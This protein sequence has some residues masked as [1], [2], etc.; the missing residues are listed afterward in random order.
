MRL[1]R[2]HR[3]RPLTLVWLTADEA[4]LVRGDGPAEEGREGPAV[5][6][7]RSG[8]PELR[9]AGG[10]VHADPRVQAGGGADPGDLVERRREHL[11]AAFV[12]EVAALVPPEDRVAVLGPGPF[13]ARFAARL[14]ADDLHHRRDRPVEDAPSGPLT[15]RQLQARWRELSGV[16]AERRLPAVGSTR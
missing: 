14:R 6:R 11:L 16:A 7:V 2:E 10:S 15:E 8:V 1:Q 12:R 5:R 3:Q 13:H 9:R 4:I